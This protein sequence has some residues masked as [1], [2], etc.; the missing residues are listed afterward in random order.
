MRP[1]LL[2]CLGL[3][4]ILAGCTTG[5]FGGQE[6]SVTVTV[7]NSA[8]LTQT[9]EVWVVN[10]E[11]TVTT[12]RDDGLTGNYT[13]GQGLATHSSGPHA[14]GKVKLPD[15]ARLHGRFIIDPGEEK[16]SSIENFSRDSAVVVVLY[17]GD[18]IGW[19]ASAHCS[20]GALVGL[21]IYTRPSRYG[22]AG[23]GYECL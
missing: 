14:W 17:Q 20:D 18:K 8:N 13:I 4:L 7:N 16:R 2:L 21:E 22:D 15:S 11:A 19:W 9:F 23:A 10:P 6:G 1:L 3:L 5:P 12:R